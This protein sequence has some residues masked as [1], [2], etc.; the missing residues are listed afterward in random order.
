MRCYANRVLCKK[1]GKSSSVLLL[2]AGFQL[3]S[4]RRQLLQRSDIPGEI[5]RKSEGGHGDD[6]HKT[7][8]GEWQARFH[9]F[10][11]IYECIAAGNSLRISQAATRRCSG[12]RHHASISS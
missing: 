1:G 10:I 5:P 4:Q 6:G 7:G 8:K 2:N 12:A 3:R 11:I 9:S